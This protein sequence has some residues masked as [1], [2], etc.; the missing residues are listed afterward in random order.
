MRRD[1]VRSNWDS[2]LQQL[3][4]IVK[5]DVGKVIFSPYFLGEWGK[6]RV[7]CSEDARVTHVC[8]GPREIESIQE[9][10]NCA[11]DGFRVFRTK[12]RLSCYRYSFLAP[13]FGW[14]RMLFCFSFSHT[15]SLLSVVRSR[16][17]ARNNNV[18]QTTAAGRGTKHRPHRNKARN[19][20]KQ[21]NDRV[22]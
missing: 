20:K 4:R 17:V 6:S 3:Q 16:D 2:S 18:S 10:R 21:K 5:Y 9:E 8:V 13:S 7:H 19:G 11:R 14:T 12:W 15:V 1:L 22:L